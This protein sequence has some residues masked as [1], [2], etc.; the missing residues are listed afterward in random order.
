MRFLLLNRRQSWIYLTLLDFAVKLFGTACYN[1]LSTSSKNLRQQDPHVE[2][3]RMCHPHTVQTG[4]KYRSII[5]ELVAAVMK[6]RGGRRLSL[7]VLCRRY[8]LHEKL[9]GNSAP[10]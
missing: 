3:P 2:V 4:K 9:N 10:F 8:D 5:S 7:T 6:R 1:T